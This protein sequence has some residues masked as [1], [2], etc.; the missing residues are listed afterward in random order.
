MGRRVV[1]RPPAI[2]LVTIV[3]LGVL[4]GANVVLVARHASEALSLGYL[5]RELRV[6]LFQRAMI[7]AVTGV[8]LALIALRRPAARAAVTLALVWIAL[9]PLVPVALGWSRPLSL[10]A[11]PPAF[12]AGRIAALVAYVALAFWIVSVFRSS[13]SVRAYLGAETPAPPGD[14]EPP[15]G[16]QSEAASPS[17]APSEEPPP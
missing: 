13:W 1:N 4:F 9:A 11:G 16:D 10:S 7:M 5:P 17:E 2:L 15:P 8:A 6:L 3:V 12:V 14:P